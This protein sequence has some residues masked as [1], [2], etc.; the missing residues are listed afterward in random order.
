MRKIVVSIHSTF[1]GVV[2]G[3]PSDPTNFM[4]WAQAGIEDTLQPFLTLMEPVDTILLGRGTYED[5]STKWPNA[6]DWPDVDE[7]TLRLADKVNSASKIVVTGNEE[8]DLA[9]GEFEPPTR[10]GGDQVEEQVAALKEQDGGD[11]V[12]FGSAVL[13][14]SL[15]DAG[16]VDEYQIIVH[17]VVVGV[18][19][20]LFDDGIG[21]HDF[22]LKSVDT[23]EHGAMLVTYV[24]AG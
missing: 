22:Q 15:A 11:I 21:Q 16:L 4:T 5:L 1:N 23:F 14:R 3:P 10:L 12:T 8:L 13:V 2:S 9:W 7:V 20:R 19:Q 24:P 18:G 6:S 17:P